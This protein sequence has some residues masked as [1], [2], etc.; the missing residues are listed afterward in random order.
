MENLILRYLLDDFN[1]TL[2]VGD[3]TLHGDG[4]TWAVNDL[5]VLEGD[6]TVYKGH[7]LTEAVKAMKVDLSGYAMLKQ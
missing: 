4:V 6:S 7:E 5:N 3:Y 2:L 1:G